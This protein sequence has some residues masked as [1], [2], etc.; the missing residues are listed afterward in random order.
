VEL[1]VWEAAGAFD[2][3][4]LFICA[5]VTPAAEV[6]FP[7]GGETPEDALVGVEPVEEVPTDDPADVDGPASDTLEVDPLGGET[8]TEG[9][10]DVETEADAPVVPADAWT[11]T[12]CCVEALTDAPVVLTTG[13]PCVET[14][15][16]TAGPEP[17]VLAPAVTP[18]DELP[19][20]A[21]TCAVALVD[22]EVVGALAD[23]F[24]AVDTAGAGAGAW[25][26]TDAC[27]VTG[28]AGAEDVVDV[29]PLEVDAPTDTEAD[30]PAAETDVLT[31]LLVEGA[32]TVEV[33]LSTVFCV[34]DTAEDVVFVAVETVEPSVPPAA[35]A[36]PRCMVHA[37]IT[38]RNRASARVRIAT[39]VPPK[40]YRNLYCCQICLAGETACAISV[41]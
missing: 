36:A 20:D 23:T 34:V 19:V 41:P 14:D 1:L 16:W 18:A 25:T 39:I 40:V 35:H 29:P 33:V 27:A 2:A 37:P 7:G 28:A 31:L 38:P 17:L 3:V 9:L 30:V 4:T 6:L 22:P 32:C 15:A 21:E 5:A 24:A 10:P 26:E 12:P 11:L 13:A 8:D